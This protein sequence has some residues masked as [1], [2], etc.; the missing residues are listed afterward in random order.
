MKND[1]EYTIYRLTTALIVSAFVVV[2]TAFAVDQLWGIAR[3]EFVFRW[4]AGLVVLGMILCVLAG[5]WLAVRY[6][7]SRNRA[8]AS[9][10]E[11]VLLVTVVFLPIAT[12]YVLRSIRR[13]EAEA[14]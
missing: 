3:F 13:R 4:L 10:A 5:W 9:P 1:T 8:P 11:Y 6:L 14:S 2:I 7:L 12:I